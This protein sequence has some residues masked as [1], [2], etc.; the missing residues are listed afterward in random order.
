MSRCPVCESYQIVVVLNHSPRA[1]CSRCGS[2]WIQE[3]SEQRRIA[4]GLLAH[5]R[6]Q[7]TARP[8]PV[9]AYAEPTLERRGA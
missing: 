5:R 4:R 7:P 9:P 8:F 2:R 1:W 3:G 6:Q